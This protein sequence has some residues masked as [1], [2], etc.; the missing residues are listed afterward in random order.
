MPTT[1][2]LLVLSLLTELSCVPPDARPVRPP[3]RQL[4]L[5]LDSPRYRE[6]EVA[7]QALNSQEITASELRWGQENLAQDGMTWCRLERERRRA[8]AA[9]PL[10]K[11]QDDGGPPELLALRLQ[12]ELVSLP[13]LPRPL[14][15]PGAVKCYLHLADPEESYWSVF[16]QELDDTVLWCSSQKALRLLADDLVEAGWS[17]RQVSCYLEELRLRTLQERQNG[18]DF[19]GLLQQ[20]TW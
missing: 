1:L 7:Q 3:V 20:V 13:G 18:H 10:Y 8:W 11:P 14:F 16:W 5:Q 15:T 4:L 2:S 12:G 6:R 9:H 17:V 19:L